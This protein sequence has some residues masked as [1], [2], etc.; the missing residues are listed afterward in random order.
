MPYIKNEDR[1]RFGPLLKD[2]ST[3]CAG[4]RISAGE[5]NYVITRLIIEW[6]GNPQ[7]WNYD[8]INTVSGF[9]NEALAEF[10]RRVVAPYEDRKIE[11]NGD[12]Y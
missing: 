8:K 12:V 11:E 4:Q 5:M 3:L 6:M 2:F 7:S 1:A 9:M 10:R